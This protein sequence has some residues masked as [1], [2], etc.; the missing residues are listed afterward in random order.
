MWQ[1]LYTILTTREGM[2]IAYVVPI[3]YCFV[4][5]FNAVSSKRTAQIRIGIGDVGTRI[6]LSLI[7]LDFIY[8]LYL[9]LTHTGKLLPAR[10]LF[11]KYVAGGL[12]WLWVGGY[13]YRRYFAPQRAGAQMKSR[14][15]ELVGIAG[16]TLVIGIVGMF[17]S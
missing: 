17:I 13:M 12:L 5:V 14:Y 3:V 15:L 6:A 8:Y 1:P 2:Y 9:F 10:Y 7:S 4:M 16:G 11:P